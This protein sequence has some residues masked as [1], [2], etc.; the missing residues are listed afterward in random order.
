MFVGLKRIEAWFLDYLEFKKNESVIAKFNKKSY[1]LKDFSEVNY[2]TINYWTEQGLVD[3]SR[4]NKKGWREFSLKDMCW[5]YIIG[6]L[7]QLGLSLGKIKETKNSL[8]DDD[9]YA[10]EFEY[11]IALVL[12]SYP[13]SLIVFNDGRG[14]LISDGSLINFKS[15]YGGCGNECFHASYSVINFNSLIRK[16]FNLSDYEVK[17]INEIGCSNTEIAVLNALRYQKDVSEVRVVL[18]DGDIKRFEV[19]EEK[20]INENI[21]QLLKESSFQDINI[22]VHNGKKVLKRTIKHK[23]TD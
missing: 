21:N 7:K 19:T 5:I 22:G 18:K 9:N 10:Y 14:T 2:R 13:I 3:D 4:V 20:S 6:E 1:R 15:L 12:S 11:Y 17:S 16:V 8:F 23:A